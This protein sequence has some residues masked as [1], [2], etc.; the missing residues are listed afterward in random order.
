MQFHF[1]QIASQNQMSVNNGNDLAPALKLLW[2]AQAW[3]LPHQRLFVKA[4]AMFL[5][6]AQHVA[7]RNLSQIY[8]RVAQTNQL[9]RGSR[10]LLVA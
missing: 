4:I 6:E 2:G 1:N 8:R 3:L 9:V 7:Q 5:P 10:S